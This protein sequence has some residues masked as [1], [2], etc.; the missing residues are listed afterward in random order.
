[1]LQTEFMRTQMQAMAEQAK[2]LGEAMTKALTDST[3]TPPKGGLS[4]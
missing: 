1:M 2:E 3:K 4:S